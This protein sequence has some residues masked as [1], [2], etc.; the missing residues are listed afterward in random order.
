VT[1]ERDMVAADKNELF[2]AAFKAMMAGH[3]AVRPSRRA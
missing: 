1:F 3:L 2:R